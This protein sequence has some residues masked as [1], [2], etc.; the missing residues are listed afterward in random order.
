[1]GAKTNKFMEI[2]KCMLFDKV[3]NCVLFDSFWGQ[4]NDNPKYISEKLHQLAPDI[5]IVW[6]VSEKKSRETIPEYAV[7]VKYG[8]TEYYKYRY[9][10]EVLVDNYTGIMGKMGNLDVSKFLRS[11]KHLRISTWHGTPLKRI[12]RDIQSRK[13]AGIARVSDYLIA[14]CRYTA[15]ILNN[16]FCDN[17]PVMLTGTPR[18]DIL[19]RDDIDSD[20]IRTKLKIPP[21]KRIVLYA[22]TFRDNIEA[23]R[24]MQMDS[25][26]IKL[27]LAGLSEKFGGEWVFVSRAHQA[28][29]LEVGEGKQGDSGVILDG[30]VGDDMAEYLSVSDVLITDYSGSLFDFALTGKPCFLYAPDREHYENKERGFYMDYDSLPFPISYTVDKLLKDVNCFDNKQY[31][32]DVGLFLKSIGNVEDGRA[33]ERI[34]LDIIRFINTGEKP[35][36]GGTQDFFISEK[37]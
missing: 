30:N 29:F 6:A 34:A 12:D 2:F 20:F 25:S 10:A 14:G 32:K 26:G 9:S 11:K 24:K 33:S 3:E 16:A 27:L 21:D 23:Y 5:K 19:F 28:I 22:P 7:P 1:M 17:Y 8:S 15:K 18:N 4:Y 37:I 13:T 35:R 36:S 31:G